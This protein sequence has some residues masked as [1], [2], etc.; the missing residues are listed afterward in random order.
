MQE[1]VNEKTIALSVRAAKMTG[2]VL[3][4]AMRKFLAEQEK[5][6]Q[7]HSAK[8][9]QKQAEKKAEVPKGRQTMKQLM[10]QNTQLTNIEVTDGNIKSFERIARKYQIDFSLKKDASLSPP[11]YVM[12]F[13]AKDVDVMTSAFKE[14]SAKQLKKQRSRR[15][16]RGLARRFSR[17]GNSTGRSSAGSRGSRGR[18]Y[19]V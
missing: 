10:G 13:K 15:F 14:Y 1:E 18:A 9:A 17:A 16:A 6:K 3:K 19:E 8:T 7:K 5:A 4:A 12:F 11:K 2:T